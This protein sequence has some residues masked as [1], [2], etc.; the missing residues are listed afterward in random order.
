MSRHERLIGTDAVIQ[1]GRLPPAPQFASAFEVRPR[2]IFDDVRHLLGLN[3][4][5]RCGRRRNRWWFYA[6]TAFI[7]PRQILTAPET[8]ALRRA[9][10]AAV[11]FLGP[12]HAEPPRKAAERRG[13][14]LPGLA[15]SPGEA[16]HAAVRHAHDVGVSEQRLGD[17]PRAKMAKRL[18]QSL[19]A[20][21]DNRLATGYPPGGT[22]GKCSLSAFAGSRKTL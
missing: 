11:A 18:L 12:S 17:G 6:D 15:H 4:P 3:A 10:L 14:Y 16:V 5:I 20:C 22:A 2:T 21:R 7:L 9:P 8:G 19:R 13:R 1:S